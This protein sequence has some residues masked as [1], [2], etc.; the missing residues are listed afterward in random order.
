LRRSKHLLK[1]RGN[2]RLRHDNADDVVARERDR[3]PVGAAI[4]RRRHVAGAH[5][6]EAAADDRA[7]EVTQLHADQRLAGFIEHSAADR[8]LFPHLHRRA[9]AT[10]AIGEH[11]YLCPTCGS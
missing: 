5:V 10:L 7:P 3:H 4:I 1:R 11:D 8:T 9:A 2:S 6:A